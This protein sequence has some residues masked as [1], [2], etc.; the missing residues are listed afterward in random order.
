MKRAL[1]N[2]PKWKPRNGF[3][4]LDRLEPGDMFHTDTTEGIFISSTPSAATVVITASKICKDQSDDNYYL[5]QQRW[6]CKTEVR[7]N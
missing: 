1:R 7:K 2:S 3:V 6:G 4:Y 5:G